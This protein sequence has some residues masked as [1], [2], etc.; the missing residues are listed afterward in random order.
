MYYYGNGVTQDYKKAERWY[1]EAAKQ[2]NLEAQFKLGDMYSYGNG[3][4]Q[5]YK[6][7]ER[8]YQ[9]AAKQGHL[10]AKGKLG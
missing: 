6:E 10:A 4:T 1:Q 8:W 2:G 5:D 7:A 9:E 3:V